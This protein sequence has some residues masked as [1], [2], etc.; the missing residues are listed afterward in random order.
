M[1]R[2]NA[3]HVSSEDTLGTIEIILKSDNCPKIDFPCN[4]V[5]GYMKKKYLPWRCVR[6]LY[7]F[8]PI[9]FSRCQVYSWL[10]ANK[11]EK[12]D[13]ISR[14]VF[15]ESPINLLELRKGIEKAV[16][17]DTQK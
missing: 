7:F 14:L 12:I 11:I 10:P 17:F 3:R 8:T 16:V 5:A 13:L 4:S 15:E 6:W 1:S 9:M 2:M